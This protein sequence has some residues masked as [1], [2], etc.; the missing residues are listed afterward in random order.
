M[1][2]HFCIV[3]GISNVP[4]S[5]EGDQGTFTHSAAHQTQE[6][7]RL[8]LWNTNYSVGGQLRGQELSL[9]LCNGDVAKI[10]VVRG[11]QN[12]GTGLIVRGRAELRQYRGVEPSLSPLTFTHSESSHFSD[13]VEQGVLQSERE[14]RLSIS[15]M[16]SP[17]TCA[18]RQTGC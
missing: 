7:H 14:L 4:A 8:T 15:Y 2:K 3:V 9:R 1:P 11:Q 16:T 6:M 10:A 12:V 5:G 17:V 18:L 13:E